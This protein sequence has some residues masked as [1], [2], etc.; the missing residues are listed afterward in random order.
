MPERADSS[1]PRDVIAGEL[2]RSLGPD[3]WSIV[4]ADETPR[5]ILVALT[6]SISDDF[7]VVVEVGG[8]STTHEGAFP[9]DLLRARVGVTYQ[10]LR[11]LWPLLGLHFSLAHISSDA[12]KGS[13][14]RWPQSVENREQAVEFAAELAASLN[15]GAIRFAMEHATLDA[16]LAD[17]RGDVLTVAALLAASGRFDEADDALAAFEGR[18]AGRDEERARA[19]YQLRRWID[20]RGKLALP[21]PR[22]VPRKPTAPVSRWLPKA[23]S[24]ELSRQVAK[25]AAFDAVRRGPRG[26]GRDVIRER[27][28]SEYQ[29][30]GLTESPLAVERAVDRL[31]P[32]PDEASE[33]GKD[34]VGRESFAGLA[35]RIANLK[36]VPEWFEPP[37]RA[38]YRVPTGPNDLWDLVELDPTGID[39]LAKAYDEAPRLGNVCVGLQAWLDSPDS[40]SGDGRVRVNLGPGRVG[41]V[42][43]AAP[44]A[45]LLS[46]AASYGELPCLVARLSRAAV[47]ESYLLEIR[48]PPAGPSPHAH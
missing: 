40:D 32:V 5:T 4:N 23:I 26:Q 42:P 38:R 36:R 14:R 24:A 16:M 19:A 47:G 2:L 6:L 34:F 30:R 28:K 3:D 1:S 10:P 35:K 21:S 41:F 31:H 8:F 22:P 29:R 11:R 13:L 39:C 15:G 18:V 20:R 33:G 44:Y 7:A 27:L 37:V 46:E 45:N 48:T 25:R 17:Q 43:D 12:F 9:V